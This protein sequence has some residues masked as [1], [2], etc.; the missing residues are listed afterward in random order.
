MPPCHSHLAKVVRKMLIRV[1]TLVCCLLNKLWLETHKRMGYT[2]CKDDLKAY[3]LSILSSLVLELTAHCSLLTAHC[4]YFTAAD[5]SV[6]SVTAFLLSSSISFTHGPYRHNKI[7][8]ATITF[9]EDTFLCLLCHKLQSS[10]P[11]L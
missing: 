4:S 1:N 3:H 11:A 6:L 5:Y 7:P 9:L 2:S 8:F 10:L